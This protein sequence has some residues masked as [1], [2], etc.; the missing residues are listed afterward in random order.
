MKNRGQIIENYWRN[1]RYNQPSKTKGCFLVDE[2]TE[3]LECNNLSSELIESVRNRLAQYVKNGKYFASGGKFVSQK[4]P[5]STILGVEH[6]HNHKYLE[7][8]DQI[9]IQ[10]PKDQKVSSIRIEFHQEKPAHRHR[11]IIDSF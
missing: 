9:A 4:K 10:I 11:R 8:N 6:G 7:N 3:I 5:N 2:V 1:F